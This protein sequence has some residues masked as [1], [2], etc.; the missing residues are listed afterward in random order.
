MSLIEWILLCLEECQM[1]IV[2]EIRNRPIQPRCSTEI[3]PSDSD[4]YHQ[5]MLKYKRSNDDMFRRCSITDV[6]VHPNNTIPLFNLTDYDREDTM[7]ALTTTMMA[8]LG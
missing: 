4:G 3:T 2:P 8:L 1:K 7:T 6:S 5:K